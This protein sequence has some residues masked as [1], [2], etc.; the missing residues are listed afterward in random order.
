MRKTGRSAARGGAMGSGRPRKAWVFE[1][2]RRP[3][4]IA[5]AALFIFLVLL[6]L[7]RLSRGTPIDWVATFESMADALTGIALLLG[8]WWTLFVLQRRRSHEVRAEVQHSYALWMHGTTQVLRLAISLRNCGEVAI[9]PGVSFTAVQKPPAKLP[10]A[11]EL[12][13][14]SWQEFERIDHPWASH[15]VVIEPGETETY[16]HDVIVP[17][18]CRYVQIATTVECEDGGIDGLNWDEVTLIDVGQLA[19]GL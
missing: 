11:Q 9:N 16:F 3:Y 7:W 17:P 5:V 10:S 12:V 2:L 15:L 14:K 18:E 13:E 1:D 6:W 19:K 8:G 4:F